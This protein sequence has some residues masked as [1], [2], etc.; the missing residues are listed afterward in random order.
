MKKDDKTRYTWKKGDIVFEPKK[1]NG[2]KKK[3]GKRSK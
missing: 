2:G 1:S 3:N